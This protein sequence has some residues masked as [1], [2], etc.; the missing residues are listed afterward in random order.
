MANV[1]QRG[2][3]GQA[4]HQVGVNQVDLYRLPPGKDKC[5]GWTLATERFQMFPRASICTA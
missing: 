3:Q 1:V 5:P 4:H 2:Y